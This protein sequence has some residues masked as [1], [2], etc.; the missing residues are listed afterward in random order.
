MTAQSPY[1]KGWREDEAMPRC[2]AEQ[3]QQCRSLQHGSA[4]PEESRALLCVSLGFSTASPY[5]DRLIVL[6]HFCLEAYGWRAW[7]SRLCQTKGPCL[8]KSPAQNRVVRATAADLRLWWC[9]ACCGLCPLAGS[10]RLRRWAVRPLYRYSRRRLMGER[11]GSPFGYCGGPCPARV[12][13]RRV[14]L[15]LLIRS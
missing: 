4:G 5:M 9:H 13:D 6:R 10:C 11:G 14:V 12:P 7:T 8:L 1:V 3:E 2:H 15:A